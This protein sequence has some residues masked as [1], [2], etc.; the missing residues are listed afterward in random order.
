MS[1]LVDNGGEDPSNNLNNLNSALHAKESKLTALIRALD[2]WN[3][4]FE[5]IHEKLC[6][7]EETLNNKDL[8]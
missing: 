1:Q 6:Q 3:Q 8:K 5:E 2:D 7:T 4:E